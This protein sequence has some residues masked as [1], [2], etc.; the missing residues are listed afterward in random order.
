MTYLP[1]HRSTHDT[2][3]LVLTAVIAV[4]V[5][6]PTEVSAEIITVNF[7]VAQADYVPTNPGSIQTISNQFAPLGLLFSDVEYNDFPTVANLTITPESTDPF[8]L[9]GAPRPGGAS[10]PDLNPSIDIRFVDP[11][12]VSR[13]GFTTF[14]SILITDGGEGDGTTLTAFDRDG[15]VLGTDQTSGPAFDQT[16]AVM[17]LG[18]IFRVNITTTPTAATAY[19]N[20]KFETVR[21]VPEP[22]L[23]ATALILAVYSLR[24]RSRWN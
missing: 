18:P 21:G 22:G 3:A 14:F 7:D 16:L 24:R 8:H 11:G 23:A 13:D 2:L 4:A 20:L 15:L 12:N 19:D 1:V 10:S 17:G 6:T 5:V 9:Y